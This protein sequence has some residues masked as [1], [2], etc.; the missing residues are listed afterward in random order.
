M[1]TPARSLT[2][3]AGLALLASAASAAT[4][5][6]TLQ[7]TVNGVPENVTLTDFP[8]LVRLSESAITGFSYQDFRGTNGSDL[9]FETA[10]GTGLAYDIDTWNDQGESLVW[11]KVPTLAKGDVLTM[12]Y[13]SAAPDA[14]DPTA[15][16]AN[17]VGVWHGND[18]TCA[19][20]GDYPASPIKDSGSTVFAPSSNESSHLGA[21][22]RNENTANNTRLKLGTTA[23]NPLVAL[24]SISQF[25]LSLWVKPT[26]TDSPSYRLASNKSSYG[27]NG[28][29]FLAISGSGT[30]IRGNGSGNAFGWWPDGY[31]TLKRRAWTHQAFTINGTDAAIFADGIVKTGSVVAPTATGS[32][33]VAIGGYAN[34]AQSAAPIVGYV[35]EIRIYN[36]VPAAAYLQAEYAQVVAAGYVS[37]GT[38][39][40]A[41]TDTPDFSVDPAVVRNANGT[42]TVTAT[43]SGVA[44]NQYDLAV[45]F[46]NTTLWSTTWTATAGAD[47]YALSWTSAGTEA[48]GTYA[49]SVVATA[50]SGASARRTTDDIFLVGDVT[51]AKGADANE[52][53]LVAGSFVLSRPGDATLPLTVAYDVSSATATAG[54]SFQAPSGTATFAAGESTVSVPI[55]P[56]NDAALKADATLTLSVLAGSGLYGGVGNTAALTLFDYAIPS[57]YNVWV[58]AYDG[59]ASSDANWSLGRAPV[60]TDNILLGA[61]SSRN[62]TWDAAASHTVASW[63]Q[64]ADYN[65]LVTFPITYENADV[66][67]GFNLFTVSGDVSVLGG[68]WVHPVQGDSVKTAGAA[69][70]VERY[71]L[72]VAVGGDFTV[73]SG[74]NISAQG[75]GRGFW[76]GGGFH[77][78]GLH[79]GY[80]I[81]ATNQ[82]HD[83]VSDPLLVPF[84]SILEP[85]ATGKG[86][87]RGN[88]GTDAPGS[89][90]HGGG[91]LHIVVGGTFSNAGRVIANGQSATGISG[92]A[93][94]SVYVRAAAIAGDG[95]FSANASA[96]SGSGQQAAGSGGRVSLIATGANAASASTASA[97]GSRAPDYWQRENQPYWEGAAGTVWLQSGT[98][99]T[100]L[101][102]NVVDSW[103]NGTYYDLGPYVRAYTP[104]P[105]DDAA[106][107]RSA[108]SGA[109]LYAASN[110]RIRLLNALRFATLQ[111][112]TETASLAHVDLAGKRLMVD[113]VVDSHGNVIATSGTFTLAD[114]LAKGW[115]WFEDSSATLNADGTAVATPGTG[116]LVIGDQATVLLFR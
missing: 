43:V 55:T 74:V 51:A 48:A 22:F 56:L 115:T 88:N 39:Q 46:G 79:A 62:L 81:T 15:V 53:G 113:S 69:A 27:D 59:N 101:V 38:V 37:Y 32:Y 109:T 85:V 93:G 50:P 106:D 98:D 4:Y 97:N 36:G 60:A 2:A 13:G 23:K 82:M 7:I 54:V 41:A 92:G 11:V 87:A 100:L 73:G 19:T 95:P 102:R 65:G 71:W 76:T 6:K 57:D 66:D 44:G 72:N 84:G 28:F 104:I 94:G 105:G 99:K 8:L 58:A 47:T 24:A 34:N 77:A 12:R 75:R 40:N 91:A 70:P 5:D 1:K 16:W 9:R 64:T 52:E 25:S 86:A 112:R 14:N 30:Q 114:A 107:S 67:A 110:A 61:W 83:A 68:A 90:G 17:Y 20:G 31:Q 103:S 33:G 78:R 89:D 29:E 111:V 10:D 45:L 96:P 21:A 116:A 63:T 35:D 80:V 49:A 3:L 18:L 26:N 108:F 42:Y